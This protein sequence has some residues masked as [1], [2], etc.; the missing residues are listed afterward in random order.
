MF[1]EMPEIPVLRRRDRKD[2]WLFSQPFFC[3]LKGK[4]AAA[5]LSEAQIHDPFCMKMKKTRFGNEKKAGIPD[6]HE[7]S[8]IYQM[9][10]PAHP[11]KSYT[12]DM[13]YHRDGIDILLN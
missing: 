11:C 3:T 1:C 7:E 13:I 2:R 5:R 6:K 10:A 9:T 8:L 12:K 4:R